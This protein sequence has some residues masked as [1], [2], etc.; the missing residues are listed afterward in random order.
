[1][2]FT[3]S[4]PAI[5]LPLLKL[6][7][8][9]VSATALFAGS[10]APDFEYFINFQMKQVHG[11]TNT[12]MFYYDFPLAILLC[13]AFHSLVRDALIHYSP[14]FIKN[15]WCHYIG[16]DWSKRWKENWKMIMVSA[17]IGVFSH[18][19]LDSFTHPHRFMTEHI[20]FL[21][22]TVSIFGSEMIVYNIGQTWGSV[23]GLMAIMAVVMREPEKRQFRSGFRTK[24]IF[25]MLAVS[26]SILILMLRNVQHAGDFI[27]TSIA[28]GLIGLMVA[29]ALM[30]TLKI[31]EEQEILY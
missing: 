8:N 27:A 25:W 9:R 3:F 11:H 17:M 7:K 30:K 26:V 15:R 21:S 1:M 12:G 2:P 13:F 19:F 31:E 14:R 23:F 4:H 6:S 29:P 16:Y 22:S 24:I 10:M 20:D 5:I 28:G 18:T